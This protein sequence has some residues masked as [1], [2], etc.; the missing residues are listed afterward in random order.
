MLHYYPRH[1]SSIN[2]PIFRRTNCI[3]AASGIVAL[4]KRL[5]STP[6]ESMVNEIILC[7][8]ARSKK[9]IKFHELC[10]HFLIL[11]SVLLYFRHDTANCLQSFIHKTKF[12]T[13][14]ITDPISLPQN[15]FHCVTLPAFSWY[16]LYC[17]LTVSFEI[18]PR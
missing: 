16:T 10:I 9:N 5:H 7:Y 14:R 15:L 13:F 6:V 17:T 12:H 8:D 1:V 4:C 11:R 2:M 3:H 18:N